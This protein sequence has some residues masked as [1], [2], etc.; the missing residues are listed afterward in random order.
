MQQH[1]WHEKH[2]IQLDWI[3]LECHGLVGLE[4]K[5]MMH[6]YSLSAM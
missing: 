3:M 6:G 4:Q 2:M 5:H 1:A